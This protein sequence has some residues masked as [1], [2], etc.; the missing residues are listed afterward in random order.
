[1]GL[2]FKWIQRGSLASKSSNYPMMKAFQFKIKLAN[3]DFS[4]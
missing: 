1:M 3:I 2:F 4:G